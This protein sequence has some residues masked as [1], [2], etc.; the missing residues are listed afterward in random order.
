MP[1]GTTIFLS[2]LGANINPEWWGEDSYEWKPDRWT[3]PLPT[4]VTEARLPGI[5]PPTWVLYSS[6]AGWT[7]TDGMFVG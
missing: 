1:S 2:L 5:Y 3:N 6:D 7:K 4:E